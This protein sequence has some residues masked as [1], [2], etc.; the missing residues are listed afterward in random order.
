MNAVPTPAQRRMLESVRDYGEP[1]AHLHGRSAHGGASGT[2]AVLRR[3][4]WVTRGVAPM[5]L[6]PAGETAL[7]MTTR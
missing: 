7:R 2:L 3:R 1:L 6:T 4:G 5:T